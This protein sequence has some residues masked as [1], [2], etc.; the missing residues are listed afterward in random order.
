MATCITRVRDILFEPVL[1]NAH[2]TRRRCTCVYWDSKG[3]SKGQRRFFPLSLSSFSHGQKGWPQL[4]KDGALALIHISDFFFFFLFLAKSERWGY[5]GLRTLERAVWHGCVYFPFLGGAV[6]RADFGSML[7]GDLL[8]MFCHLLLLFCCLYYLHYTCI[9]IH[10]FVYTVYCSI[11]T[12]PQIFI[13]RVD[14]R[15]GVRSTEV[16]S[17]TM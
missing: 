10:K 3:P 8:S 2:F 9:Y 17:D 13:V 4:A 16:R 11:P 15:S 1:L 6:E 5:H 12:F 7:V 14:F